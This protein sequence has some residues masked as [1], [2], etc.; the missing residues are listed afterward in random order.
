MRVIALLV[1]GKEWCRRRSGRAGP[2]REFQSAGGDRSRS[3]LQVRN[4]AL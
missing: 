4:P 2:R 1:K 3:A